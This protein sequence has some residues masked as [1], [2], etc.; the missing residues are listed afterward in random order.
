MDRKDSTVRL[1]MLPKSPGGA[2]GR[3]REV[4]LVRGE[5]KLE[6]KAARA[7]IELDQA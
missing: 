3:T 7:I 1:N 2:A 4:V 6:D 5:I